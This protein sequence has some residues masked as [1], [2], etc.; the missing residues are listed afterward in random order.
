MGRLVTVN[1]IWQSV[2]RLVVIWRTVSAPDSLTWAV[3][4]VNSSRQF[5]YSFFNKTTIVN[6]TKNTLIYN[7]RKY[8]FFLN[9]G[10]ES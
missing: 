6:K 7:Y 4:S 8:N 9:E 3:N 1:Y 2:I 10:L 5:F